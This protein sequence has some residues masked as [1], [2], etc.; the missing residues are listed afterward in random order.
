MCK[1]KTNE[2][3][4]RRNGWFGLTIAAVILAFIL[5]AG[6]LVALACI[7]QKDPTHFAGAAEAALLSNGLAIIGLA[8]AVWTGMNIS[9]AIQRKEV[10]ELQAAM[11]EMQGQSKEIYKAMAHLEPSASFLQEVL[12]TGTDYS[13]EFFY[14]E[15]K[16]WPGID[17]DWGKLL[18]I[19]RLFSLVLKKDRESV[20]SDITLEQ[21]AKQAVELIESIDISTRD[22][23]HKYLVLRKGE[24]YY[25]WARKIEDLDTRCRY[26]K[27]AQQSYFDFLKIMGASSE[28]YCNRMPYALEGYPNLA[29]Y[30][31]NTLCALY[32]EVV[33]KYSTLKEM[34]KFDPVLLPF[35]EDSIPKSIEYG[36]YAVAWAK[37]SAFEGNEIIYR[38]LGCAYEW[39]DRLAANQFTNHNEVFAN[40]KKAFACMAQTDGIS[41]FRSR[42]VYH[43][44]LSYYKKYIEKALGIEYEKD[45]TANVN[46]GLS[47]PNCEIE[48]LLSQFIQYSDYALSNGRKYGFVINLNG[49]AYCYA[50]LAEKMYGIRTR[51]V[52][53]QE[54]LKKAESVLHTLELIGRTDG[55][56]EVYYNQLQKCCEFLQEHY[57]IVRTDRDE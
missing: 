19:E 9:N 40:Y 55:D 49:F 25:Y 7:Y 14:C 22:I 27:Q 54:C 52:T 26:F 16:K 21:T 28:V 37:S 44:L 18:Q 4:K 33:Q 46:K 11:N 53:D 3:K 20:K 2:T 48:E 56:N 31:A 10:D 41:E 17:A 50:A 51:G 45:Y 24:F 8:I 23:V 43:V 47:L 15:F 13:S 42:K 36:G 5:S 29:V 34:H 39:E 35:V 6:T 38:N 1:K 12:K 57:P 30:I 32:V